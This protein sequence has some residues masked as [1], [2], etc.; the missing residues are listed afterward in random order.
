MPAMIINT[1]L[2][3]GHRAPE[4]GLGSVHLYRDVT[5]YLIPLHPGSTAQC[6]K[7]DR[8]VWVKSTD[9]LEVQLTVGLGAARWGQLEF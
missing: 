3:P 4:G 1:V 5:S 6:P 7:Q 9:S 8:H 2:F